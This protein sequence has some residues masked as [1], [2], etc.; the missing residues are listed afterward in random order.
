MLVQFTVGNFRSFGEEVTLNMVATNRLTSHAGHC[1]PLPGTSGRNVLRTAVIYGANAAGKSNLVKALR[2]GQLAITT[3]DQQF[4]AAQPFRFDPHYSSLPSMFEFRF[5]LYGHVFTYGFDVDRERI[6][7]EWLSVFKGD[8]ELAIFNRDEEG[9]TTF[10]RTVVSLF[11]RDAKAF[12]TLGL[13]SQIQLTKRQLFLNR[14]S[15]I[16]APAQGTIVSGI[17][18]WLTRDLVVLG[19]ESRS[20]DIVD[21]LDTDPEF[22]NFAQRFLHDVG[23]GVSDLTVVKQERT[24]SEF[25]R[26]LLSEPWPGAGGV[27]PGAESADESDS[28]I[29][30]LDASKII[31]RTVVSTHVAQR[32]GVAAPLPFS[33][34]SDGTK[35]LLHLMPVIYPSPQAD[36]KVVVI[37]ELDRSLHPLICREFVHFFGQSYPGERRQLIVT[38]HEAHLLDQ[39]LLRRDE[40]WFVE[41]DENQQSRLFSLAEFNIRKDLQVEKGYLHGRFGAVPVIGD[42]RALER[43]LDCEEQEDG[44]GAL[45]KEAT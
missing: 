2:F 11:P 20:R 23:T 6:S 4:P 33:E 22:R 44:A 18:N 15:S 14:I 38:T 19:A 43:L 42:L 16:P 26:Q 25:E 9:K 45:Q 30:P 27:A 39:D 7:A 5:L 40:Y 10:N 29:D 28:R 8:D 32:Q 1:V 36:S 37:D 31:T 21:R 34:E 35:Q 12:E 41:K 3:G 17:V 13:L 24:A